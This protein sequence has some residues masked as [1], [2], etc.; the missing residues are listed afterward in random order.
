MT[1]PSSSSLTQADVAKLLAEPSPKARAD[2]ANKLSIEIDN[3]K[4]N[5]SEL[6]IAHDIV[7]IMA[8]DA[9]ASV[10]QALAESLRKAARMPHDVAVKLASDIESVALPILQDSQVLTDEDLVTI[11]NSSGPTKQEAIAAR[12]VV[13]EKVSDIL[14]T[15][16][17]EKV[18]AKL[19][20]NSGARISEPSLNKAVDR[21]HASDL[22][23]EKMVTRDALPMAVT[24]RL[25]T[26]VSENLKDYLVR[27]H[28]MSPT[29]AANLVMQSRE[30][31]TIA[32][33]DH[34]S[35]E[36][37][38][39]MV[40][41]MHKNARLTP[42]IILRSICMGDIAFFEMS[43]AVMANVPVMNARILIHDAGRLG[44]KSLYA[45]TS[46]PPRLM[47][48]FRVAVDVVRET[49]MDGGDHD[50]ERYQGRVIERI[51]TQYQ[52]MSNDDLDYLLDKL[53]TAEQAAYA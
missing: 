6:Q 20:D 37:L 19:M 16:G 11:I 21:F 1:N 2:L 25:V 52:D 46:L 9:E 43:L 49:T 22:V 38:E 3:P 48:A 5:N 23:K 18:V 32:L 47:P 28:E 26:M 51:L 33:S 27:H 29:M 14:I 17:T 13:S 34:S 31:A 10:R 50:R 36:E 8:K 12:A 24:E 44:L 45:K 41:Q 39:K 30:R 7:R 4:L 15:K 42:S 35:D 40:T 53:G